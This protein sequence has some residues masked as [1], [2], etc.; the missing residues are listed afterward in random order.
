MNDMTKLEILRSARELISD[1]RRWTKDRLARRADGVGTGPHDVGAISWCAVGAVIK[2]AGDRD[3]F[4]IFNALSAQCPAGQHIVSFN[5]AYG[6]SHSDILGVFDR[7]IA[8][9][10]LK[11]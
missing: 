3:R 8:I 10:E 2:F 1:S 7:A 6:T 11:Q 5:N 9:E 4:F